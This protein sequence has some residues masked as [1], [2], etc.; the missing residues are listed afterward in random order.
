MHVIESLCQG[1]ARVSHV[2]TPRI[3]LPCG[4]L[5]IAFH[6]YCSCCLTIISILCPSTSLSQKWLSRLRQGG[7]TLDRGLHGEFAELAAII[8]PKFGQ[9][10][11]I[12]GGLLG[13]YRA[14]QYQTWISHLR[15][16]AVHATPLPLIP[17]SLA[18]AGSCGNK[19][20]LRLLASGTTS[21]REK[22]PDPASFSHY[23]SFSGF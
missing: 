5:R 21:T 11:L 19:E 4:Q 23:Y 6:R 17:C 22:L 12:F 3:G 2:Q 16:L 14:F 1:N 20:P 10:N 18:V 13:L 8:T 9:I 15:V 7:M